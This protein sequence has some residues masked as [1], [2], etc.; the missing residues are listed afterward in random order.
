MFSLFGSSWV[1]LAAAAA[2]LTGALAATWFLARPSA[3]GPSARAQRQ[4]PAAPSLETRR[5][6]ETARPSAEHRPAAPNTRLLTVLQDTSQKPEDIQA[7]LEA[8]PSQ[9]AARS[10]YKARPDA[11]L[12]RVLLRHAESTRASIAMAALSAARIPLMTDEPGAIITDGLVAMAAAP[13][14]PNRRHAALEALNLIRPNRRKPQVIAAFEAALSA[15]NAHLI[16]LALFALSQSGPSLG[17]DARHSSLSARVLK[18]SDHEDP[19]VRG[20]ALAV[21]SEIEDFVDPATRV[22]TAHAHLGDD[23]AYVRAQA[24]DLVAR[25]R[26]VTAIHRLI[27]HVSDLSLARYDLRGWSHLDGTPGVLPHSLPGRPRVADA[28]L[29]SIQSLSNLVEGGVPL[30][31]TL[32]GPR[33]SDD[34]VL[35][36]AARARAWYQGAKATIPIEVSRDL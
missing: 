10:P 27:E 21:L 2:L 36:N 23:H 29:F 30:T 8:I 33:V 1:R 5:V 15:Q 14:D 18:L 35:E 22:R 24:A 28:A 6:T 19:G 4:V 31:L 7:A 9:Y 3:V 34:V 16:S 17:S 13:G 26:D 11:E 12:E 20:R 32:G 25:C